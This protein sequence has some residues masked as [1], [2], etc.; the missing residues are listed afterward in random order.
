MFRAIKE[1]QKYMGDDGQS[2]AA[3]DTSP[4]VPPGEVA[5]AQFWRFRR[6]RVGLV[7]AKTICDQSMTALWLVVHCV[8]AAQD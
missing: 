2:R 8:I 4:V 7:L 1:S 3:Y 6:L 5:D